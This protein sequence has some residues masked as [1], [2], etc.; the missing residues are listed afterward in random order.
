MSA[1]RLKTSPQNNFFRLI[2]F[3]FFKGFISGGTTDATSGCL[4]CNI[5]QFTHKIIIFLSVK[6]VFFQFINQRKTRPLFYSLSYVMHIIK[7]KER[8]TYRQQWQW[9]LWDLKLIVM[10]RTP[11]V[12]VTQP[13]D[14]MKTISRKQLSDSR[15]GFV[16]SF[17]LESVLE[18][19]KK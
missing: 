16:H 18:S 13:L 2:F 4:T 14:L 12:I 7:K 15:E 8:D 19:T 9:L 5:R 6:I 17:Q 3:T 11:K 10:M 1:S